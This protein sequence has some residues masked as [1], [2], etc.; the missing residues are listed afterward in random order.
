MGNGMDHT[1]GNGP[2]IVATQMPGFASGFSARSGGNVYDLN[3][4]IPKGM[5]LTGINLGS[6]TLGLV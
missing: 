3:G 4:A 2:F 5:G 6:S 1:S